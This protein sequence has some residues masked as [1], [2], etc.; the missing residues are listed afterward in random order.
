MKRGKK[1]LLGILGVL[2]IAILIFLFYYNKANQEALDI[3]S[4]MD[5]VGNDYYFRGDSGV[6]FIIFTGAKMDEKSY[7]YIAELLHKEGHTVVL[8]KFMFH[9]SS[10]GTNRGIEIMESNPEI[11]KWF[12]IGHS[13]GGMP[14]SRIAV[15]KPANLQGLAFLASYVSTDLSELDV[16]AIH[17]MASNDNFYSEKQRAEE[18]LDYLPKNSTVITIEGASHQGF[19]AYD[20]WGDRGGATLPWKEQ[21]KQAVRM[22]L[23]FFDAQINEGS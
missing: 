10:T 11:E 16:S 3:V 7:A 17:I 15:Q 14:I 21:Q 1:M 2:A 13:I 9:M 5:K 19:G 20:S 22:M 8:P 4:K 23:D 6:G 12:L 18:R